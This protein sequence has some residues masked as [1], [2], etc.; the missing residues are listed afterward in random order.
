MRDINA[1]ILLKLVAENPELPIVAMV[2]SLCVADDTHDWW[3][4]K[5]GKPLV[6]E[7]CDLDDRVYLKSDFDDLVDEFVENN[8]D[9]EPWKSMTQEELEAEANKVVNGYNWIKAIM[10]PITP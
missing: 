7:Y 1:D 3:S 6:D 5:I 2:D 4:A 10:L 8:Y 9:D